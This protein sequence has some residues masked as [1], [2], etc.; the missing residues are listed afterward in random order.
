[1]AHPIRSI[2]IL[3]GGT[4]GWIAAAF[5]NRFLDPARCRITL[6]ESA[7]IGTIGVGEATVPPLVSLLRL[8][9]VEEDAFLRA[10]HATY[11]LAI[12]F[13]GW[14]RRPVWH[15]FGHVGAGQL[16]GHREL[17][18]GHAQAARRLGVEVGGAFSPAREG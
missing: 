3:G 11:K 4:S 1:M 7:A 13:D 8:L 17:G 14:T 18:V 10:C 12:R 2:L 9:G 15:P 6:V 5:L 16:G